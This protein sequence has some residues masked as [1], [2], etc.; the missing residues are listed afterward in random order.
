MILLDNND[1]SQKM[2]KE[3]RKFI[4]TEFSLEASAKNFLDVV[5][6]HINKKN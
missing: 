6:Q 4:E 2:G 3:G 1:L 5:K